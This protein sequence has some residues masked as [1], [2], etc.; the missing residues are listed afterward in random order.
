MHAKDLV[1]DERGNGH[2]VED[3][4]E[5]LPDADGIAAL[6]LVVETVDAID[7]AAFVISAQQE[8]VLLELDLVGQ[9]QNDGLQGVLAA[10]NVVAEE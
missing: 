1:V 5:F 9:E 10:V 3:V 8:K 7:L 6:A 4:L 2:A